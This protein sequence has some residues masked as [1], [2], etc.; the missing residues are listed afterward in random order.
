MRIDPAAPT[1]LDPRDTKA[2]AKTAAAPSE[3]AAVVTLSPA[4]S[5]TA[6]PVDMTARIAQIR[7]LIRAG[8]YPVDLNALAS[9]IVDDEILRSRGKS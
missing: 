8:A 4:A 2:P 1:S 9:K 3:G 5:A 7:A 6:S